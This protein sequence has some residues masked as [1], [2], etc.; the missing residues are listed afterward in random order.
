MGFFFFKFVFFRSFRFAF[1]AAWRFMSCFWIF[2]ICFVFMMKPI[3]KDHSLSGLVWT[4]QNWSWLLTTWLNDH[5][6]DSWQISWQNQWG[7]NIKQK[8]LF[9]NLIEFV[10]NFH[11]DLKPANL[12]RATA[13]LASY[14]LVLVW[15]LNV[16][17]SRC[18][19][20]MTWAGAF[21]DG[22]AP[23]VCSAFC[24]AAVYCWGQLQRHWNDQ[25]GAKFKSV[26]DCCTNGAAEFLL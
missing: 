9:L 2:C 14:I 24:T 20:L 10:G 15:F 6:H 22:W 19:Y 23:L 13:G 17:C 5:D 12:V 26:C 21:Q 3:Y 8:Q 16:A 4:S 1:L 7:K 11:R 18:S 25:E